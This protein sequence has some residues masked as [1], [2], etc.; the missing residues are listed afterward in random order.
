ML[1]YLISNIVFTASSEN[2]THTVPE[3]IAVMVSRGALPSKSAHVRVLWCFTSI[4]S[5]KCIWS[6][7]TLLSTRDASRSILH[8]RLCKHALRSDAFLQRF[9][10]TI[11]IMD[12][13]Y[14]DSSVWLSRLD[15]S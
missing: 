12:G 1:M 2:W 14:T 6:Q 4:S 15:S 3:I 8:K 10:K 5:I 13:Y 7:H 9:S 11:Y